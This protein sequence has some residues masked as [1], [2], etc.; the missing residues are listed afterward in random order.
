MEKSTTEDEEAEEGEKGAVREEDGRGGEVSLG[1][2][3][4]ANWR[5]PVDL[6]SVPVGL[7]RKK[8]GEGEVG[9]TVVGLSDVACVVVLSGSDGGRRREESVLSWSGAEEC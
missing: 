9:K 4:G 2:N 7:F 6:S 8:E 1:R 3:R 5:A